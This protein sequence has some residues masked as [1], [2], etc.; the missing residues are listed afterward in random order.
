MIE[1]LINH[2]RN[3]IVNKGKLVDA[4][5][6]NI[7]GTVNKK[8]I[9]TVTNH[10]LEVIVNTVANGDKVTIVGFGSFEPRDRAAREGRNPKT[11]EKME[12]AA[13]RIPAFSAG[14]NFKEA[15]VNG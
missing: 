5:S 14:K 1:Q 12:I 6:K 7:G 2:Q 9:E 13:T 4:I 3:F 11:G 10:L 8:S 15:V